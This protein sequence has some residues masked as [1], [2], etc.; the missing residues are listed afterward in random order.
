MKKID[1]FLATYDLMPSG[2]ENDDYDSER[3]IHFLEELLSD[4][5]LSLPENELSKFDHHDDLS[6]PRPPPKPPDVETE[7]ASLFGK[8]KYE[9]N[10]INKIYE[11]KKSKS[12]VSATPLSTAF[13]STTI[14][15]DF[16]DNLDDEKD[17]RSSHEYL[18][19]LEE[20]YQAKALLAK[21]KRFFKKGTQRN[22]TDPSAIVSDSSAP[23]YDLVD[24]S[25]LCSTPLLPLKKLD[26]AK[27]GSG[28]K[29]V[30]SILKSKSMLKDENL[31]GIILNEPSLAPTRGNKSSSASKNNLAPA[32]KLKNVNLKDDPLLAMVI[33]EL[34]ELKI[35]INKKKSSYS[36]NKNTQ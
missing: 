21:S 33:E 35:Q 27:P 24:E 23:D 34:I 32:G 4:D 3:D 25:S 22:T 31:K 36:R 13:F 7:L 18:N 12:L 8:L 29:I 2:I 17:T 5:P 26:G 15:Q 10:L 14:S 28:P 1:S 11:T 6:F 16:Q 19:D 9:E 20:E 30:K